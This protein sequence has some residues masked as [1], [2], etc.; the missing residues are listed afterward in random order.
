M[1]YAQ[2]F[3]GTIKPTLP[4]LV[5]W[6][7]Q[8]VMNGEKSVYIYNPS[9]LP[10]T[11]AFHITQNPPSSYPIIIAPFTFN[12]T[13]GAQKVISGSFLVHHQLGTLTIPAFNSIRVIIKIRDI[14]TMPGASTQLQWGTTGNI[15]N[16]I[17]KVYKTGIG[18]VTPSIN[19]LVK[20]QGNDVL[21]AYY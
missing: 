10:V 11:A 19:D 13:L 6:V 1:G 7:D 14:S 8:T 4:N 16:Y 18:I 17:L 5:Y 2:L 20:L 12:D 15:R 3:G 21:T 9:W